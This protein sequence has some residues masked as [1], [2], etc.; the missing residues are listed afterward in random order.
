[1]H[2][3]FSRRIE[4]ALGRL[5]ARIARSSKRLDPTE[6]NRQIGRILQQNQRAAARFEVR[7]ED[8]GGPAGF[9]LHVECNV[10]F[11]DWAALS[12]CAYLL[13]SNITDWS[14]EQLFAAIVRGR[15]T[16]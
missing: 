2:E 7:P 5:A 9:R 6:V 11:D 14:D 1:V 16:P 3:K 12:K 10:S 8:D 13:R 15:L 4:V